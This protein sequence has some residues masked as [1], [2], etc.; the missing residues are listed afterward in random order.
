MKS[1]LTPVLP[2]YPAISVWV[3]DQAA[4]A[5]PDVVLAAVAALGLIMV[6]LMDEVLV[7]NN[8]I[9]DTMI[10]DQTVSIIS[11]IGNLGLGI[12]KLFFGFLIGSMALVADGIHSSIDVLSSSIT[13]IGL[14]VAKKPEDEK[15]PYGYQ[16]A[17]S[18]AGFF[19][20]LFLGV[21]GVWIIYEAITRFLGGD[22]VKLSLGA[23][24]VVI[25]SILVAEGLAR[26]K[27]HYGRKYKSLAL[28]ADGEHSR[29]D[30][31]SSVGVL[32]GLVLANYFALADA[33]VALIIGIYIVY[34]AFQISKEITDSLL[35]VSNK[36]VEERI[37]KICHSHNI[38]ISSL[39]TRQI[40]QSNFA[41]IKIKLPLRLKLDK[42]QEIT[43]TLEERL[44]NN[45]PYLS[46]VI[47]AVEA[48]DA[49][50]NTVVPRLGGRIGELKGFEKIGP[51]KVGQRFLI[52]LVG[53]N[54]AETFG[55]KD[56]LIIDYKNNKI[57]RKEKMEN[58]YFQENSP[59]G[60][61]FI[62]AVRGDKI[63]TPQIGPNA[64]QNLNSFGIEVEVIPEDKK[65]DDVLTLI[66]EMS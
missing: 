17:E 9:E 44:L 22:L 34:E 57:V 16:K 41:E 31:L 26:L 4:G 30:A 52:P 60:A 55:A 54:I 15:H 46:Q 27:F 62:K 50:T 36:E 65:V 42:V 23:I 11:V 25:A 32:I 40:G 35:D 14:R 33:I 28:V 56:Y 39:K 20:A 43:E 1:Y 2:R 58:P 19:V 5:E 24:L 47:I 51:V 63:F 59:H 66:E 8:H 61:R 53:D 13:Y 49:S 18:I 10:N 21:S 48:Y 29:A 12:S 6:P 37:Q 7:H 64:R 3:E 45:I 38:E